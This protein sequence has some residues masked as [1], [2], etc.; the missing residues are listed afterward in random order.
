M[1]T[2]NRVQDPKAK[3]QLKDQL[4]TVKSDIGEMGHLVKSAASETV[5]DA[6]DKAKDFLDEKREQT[7]ELEDALLSRV[8]NRPLESVAIAAGVG[9][10]LGFLSRR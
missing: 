10:V 1:S 7:R 4:D 9:L 8:R 3:E 2:T 5:G 6:K